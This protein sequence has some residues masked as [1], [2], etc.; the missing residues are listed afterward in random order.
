MKDI[1]SGAVFDHSPKTSIEPLNLQILKQNARHVHA[2]QFIVLVEV[3]EVKWKLY[4]MIG[5]Y[6]SAVGFVFR[7]FDIYLHAEKLLLNIFTAA[8][9][10]V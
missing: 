7:S 3:V 6:I 2:K 1:S 9:G 10:A 5:I 8:A 4:S